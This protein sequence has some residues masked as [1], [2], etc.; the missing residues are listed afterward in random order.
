MVLTHASYYRGASHIDTGKPV[1]DRAAAIDITYGEGHQATALLLADGHGSEAHYRSDLGAEMAIAAASEALPYILEILPGRVE[2]GASVSRGVADSV[3]QSATDRTP[4][5]PRCEAAMRMFFTRINALWAKKVLEHW[6]TN[7]RPDGASSLAGA[8]RAYGCTLIG[9]VRAD[10]LWY[11]FQLGDGAC[12][13]IG[14]DGALCDPVPGDSRCR[15]SRTTS[16]CIHGAKDF[17][18]AYGTDVPPA[19]MLCSDGLADC[20]DNHKSLA[21]EFLAQIALDTVHNGFDSVVADIAQSLPELSRQY[22]R[23]DISIALWIDN[24]TIAD[25]VPGICRQRA[26]V[27]E[28]ELDQAYS[29][30]ESC[31]KSIVDLEDHI[32]NLTPSSAPDDRNELERKLSVLSTLKRRQ[33]EL[34]DQID[35]IRLDLDNSL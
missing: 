1:Q 30:L 15:L 12:V 16:M 35:S 4:A 23:D 32:S 8:A 5:D 27:R 22:T 11:A 26:I 3:C 13:A 10:T 6:N 31:E 34:L 28:G 2:P 19:L 29:S 25:V 20:F 24:D 33:R 17:R 18:Y 14:P 21:S 7:P 9:A